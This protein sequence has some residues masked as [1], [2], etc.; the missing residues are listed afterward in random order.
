MSSAGYA[1]LAEAIG[2]VEVRN[3]MIVMSFISIME[4][5]FAL[6]WKVLIFFLPLLRYN[7]YITL[8]FYYY[9]LALI[10]F[11]FS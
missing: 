10:L 4:G 5:I 1:H 8:I 2:K 6:F 11:F 9:L 3:N 7:G